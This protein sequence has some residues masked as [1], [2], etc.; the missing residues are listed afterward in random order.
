MLYYS[1]PMCVLEVY[2]RQHPQLLCLFALA[3]LLL[4]LSFSFSSQEEREHSAEWSSSSSAQLLL[5]IERKTKCDDALQRCLP[6]RSFPYFLAEEV[7]VKMAARTEREMGYFVHTTNTLGGD[8]DEEKGEEEDA[9]P[10]QCCSER[11]KK[12]KSTAES[13]SS[14]KHVE[15]AHLRRECSFS[16]CCALSLPLFT[17]LSTVLT[18]TLCRLDGKR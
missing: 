11:Q 1:A 12:K 18:L 9:S 17:F 8:G 5:G 3:F 10:E 16:P 14:S 7:K 13:S 4:L 6:A 2:R 15:Y